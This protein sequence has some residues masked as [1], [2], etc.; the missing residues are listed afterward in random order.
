MRFNKLSHSVFKG[1]LVTGQ[2]V[3]VCYITV[4]STCPP[5]SLRGARETETEATVL[6]FYETNT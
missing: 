1:R 6:P 3:S 2:M 4:T 5:R